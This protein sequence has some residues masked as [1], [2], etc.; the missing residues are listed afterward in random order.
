MSRR[1]LLASLLVLAC[2]K[3]G[4]TGGDAGPEAPMADGPPPIDAGQQAL[5]V[6]FTV[7]GCPDFDVGKPQCKGVA[8]L[9][10]S[11]VPVTSPSVGTFRWDFGDKTGSTARAP[12][13][14]FPLPGS[15][16]VALVVAAAS[17]S[18]P[19]KRDMFIVVA[20]AA[21]GAPCDVDAQC[22]IG[23]TCLCGTG[24][25]GCPSGFARG[26]C[27]APCAGD[28]GMGAA[29]VDFARSADGDS[30]AAAEPWRKALCLRACA[31][32]ADCAPG[33]RCRVLPGALP[34]P[35]SPWT[36]ACWIDVPA[37]VGAPC[38]TAMGTLRGATCVTGA[39]LDVG[40][41]GM[42][43][44]DCETAACPPESACARLGDGRA[45]CLHACAG[46]GDCSSDPLLACEPPGAPGA[47]GFSVVSPP[48]GATFC[49]PRHCTA[50][51]DCGLAA[52]C[53]SASGGMHCAR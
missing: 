1:A 43:S 24:T 5:A 32:D 29:C 18:A 33:L 4:A 53:K 17:E 34:A 51:A 46:T 6:D 30:A 7:T 8:P 13:H 12:S 15:Y 2:N 20:P 16:D 14:T 39:C 3:G 44:L 37:A 28:C 36:R 10:V 19:R 38:R 40:A 9:T 41:L 42:C 45:L 21:T 23:R 22:E 35:A 27:T 48:A 49:A 25:M 31:V 47:L 52:K 11:F 50:D 26:V